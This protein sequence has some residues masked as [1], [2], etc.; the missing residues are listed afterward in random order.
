P[1]PPLTILPK[2]QEVREFL[3][4]IGLMLDTI[5]YYWNMVVIN[6]SFRDQLRIVSKLAQR[7]REFQPHIDRSRLLA[8]FVFPILAGLLFFLVRTRFFN[9]KT[10]AKR[11]IGEFDTIMKR[12]G[13]LRTPN[14][15][16]QEFLDRVADGDLRERAQRFVVAFEET[17]YRDQPLHHAK[18][19]SLRMLLRAI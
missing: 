18:R 12:R 10:P 15:G 4:K 17:F 6:Y 8:L 13:Y 9:R 1:P 14:E 2:Y 19:R 3:Q 16:L 5:N 11:L 7:A